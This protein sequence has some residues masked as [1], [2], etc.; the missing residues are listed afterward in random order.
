VQSLKYASKLLYGEDFREELPEPE[1]DVEQI[2]LRAA[3]QIDKA[4]NPKTFPDYLSLTKGI[5]KLGFFVAAIYT[6]PEAE[7]WGDLFRPEGVEAIL[8]DLAAHGHSSQDMIEIYHA[9][10]QYRQQ[11]DPGLI[12]DFEAFR[13]EI[14]LTLLRETLNHTDYT[15]TDLDA[16]MAE[17]L[18][19]KGFSSLRTALAFWKE[20]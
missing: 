7:N 11:R 19:G 5:F 18:G 4:F 15:W 1:L 14:S 3:Y 8:Q 2:F 12:P 17:G 9:A 6:D 10:L 20:G 13:K 16:L